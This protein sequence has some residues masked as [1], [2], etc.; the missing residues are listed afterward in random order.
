MASQ[1]STSSRPRTVRSPGSP[2]PGADEVDRHAAVQCWSR[3]SPPSCQACA[4][5]A[6]VQPPPS[7]R[8]HSRSASTAARLGAW[9]SAATRRLLAGAHLDG[10]RALSGLGHELARVE[11]EGDP[12]AEAEALEAR[13][14]E[15]DR[16]GL[17]RV[18]LRKPGLDVAPQAA[19]RGCRAAAPRGAP[20]GVPTTC[21][22]ARRKARP[23]GSRSRRRPRRGGRPAPGSRRARARRACRR[24]GPWRCARPR[25]RR[26]AGGRARCRA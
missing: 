8:T 2:G 19:P 16:V 17:T 22:P 14:G 1:R 15:H 13:G 24:S 21:R 23:R 12:R 25:P 11:Q 18:E 20:P 26:H 6:A 5:T 7:R 4:A 9:S 10:D 3:S